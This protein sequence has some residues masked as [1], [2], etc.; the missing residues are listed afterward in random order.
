MAWLA[1]RL[2]QRVLHGA[3][4]QEDITRN[5]VCRSHRMSR[6]LL[7]RWLNR[8]ARFPRSGRQRTEPSN[9]RRSRLRLETLEGRCLPSTVSNLSDHDPGS[10]RDAI[11]TTPAGGTV[12][13]Q[14]GLSG[15][16]TL[17]SGE[18]A[19]N[20]DL[21]IAGPGANVITVSGNSASRVFEIAATYTVGI[22]GLTIADGS[23]VNGDNGGGI[24]N[25]GTLT[26]SASTISNNSAMG[27]FLNG[28]G[29]GIYNSG[30]LSI[31][32]SI[33]S[34]NAAHNTLGG[35]AGGGI[36]N[37]SDGALTI[38]DCTL[39][40]N[41]TNGSGGAVFNDY[42]GALALTNSSLSS[43][44]AQDGGG[45]F[46]R[47]QLTIT[48]SNLSGNGTDST[49]PGG[50]IF[51]DGNGRLTITNSTFSGNSNGAIYNTSSHAT[52]TI[53]GSTFS[54]ND[55]GIDNTSYGTLT[56][57]SSTLRDNGNGIFN[58]GTL[59]VIACTLSGNTSANV[60]AAIDNDDSRATA[61][62][63]DS[64]ISGNSTDN[65]GGAVENFGTLTIV[66]STLSGNSALGAGGGD[67]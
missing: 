17:T 58:D 64:T 65:A 37:N 6:L 49:G 45:I 59:T 61:T 60:G 9:R 53:T 10:L 63:I 33:V 32:N 5:P 39:S 20:K 28:L 67:L 36:Y 13:F 41:S 15:T 35:D 40:G 1:S 50:G 38:T 52:L 66:N 21:T 54:G 44:T 16:I 47:G 34:G 25:S 48:S 55:G 7:R 23:V 8:M 11:A 57:T 14:A 56:I 62:I 27:I 18:L 51:N 3:E 24:L 43:N 31:T 22:S 42:T 26:V 46:N 2:L 19:I 29:G 12:D 30:T 4:E